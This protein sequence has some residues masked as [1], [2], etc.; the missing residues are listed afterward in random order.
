M[1]NRCGYIWGETIE[2]DFEEIPYE[3]Y[4]F[5][6]G[7]RV[8]VTGATGLVGSLIIRYIIWLNCRYDMK[9]SYV[10]VVRNKE[11]ARSIFG[12]WFSDDN[13][14]IA[15]LKN[16]AVEIPGTVDYIVHAAAIT[17]S[18][19]MV[20]EPVDLIQLSL[21]GTRQILELAKEKQAVCLYLSSMEVYG[22]MESSNKVGENQLGYIDLMSVRSCYPESK[23]LCENLCVAYNAQYGV[24]VRIARLAQTFG[25]GVLSGEKRAVVDFTRRAAYGMPIVLKTTGRSE[26]NYVYTSDALAA[27]F[28][29]LSQGKPTD[30]FNV[31]NSLCH[32]TIA[33]MAETA[34][35]VVGSNGSHLVFD[36]D[37]SNE[38]GYAAETKLYLDDSKLRKLGWLPRVDLGTAMKRLVSY[39]EERE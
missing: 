8:V 20:E 2:K 24:D 18:R 23:R 12:G 6:A 26:A 38:N 31:A 19:L 4:G 34:I 7:K 17:Q 14:Y 37:E 25:A 28:R 10:G 39:L 13:F 35:H 3:S 36:V 16:D 30:V 15:D 27:L 9:I 22:T 29:I 21:N 33:E 5:L 32:T 11:K 1:N